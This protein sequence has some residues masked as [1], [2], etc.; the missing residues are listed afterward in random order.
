[1]TFGGGTFGGPGA[2]GGV[3]SD[4]TWELPDPQELL[5]RL[6]REPGSALA[7]LTTTA[8][9][10][11]PGGGG[12]VGARIYYPRIPAGVSMPRK[13]V[14]F[15]FDG[16]TPMPGTVRATRWRVEF[17]L[18]GEND[19]EAMKV[20][21]ALRARSWALRNTLRAT[22]GGTA[23]LLGFRQDGAARP[24][25]EDPD[26]GWRFVLT[27]YGATIADEAIG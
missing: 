26:T 3:G 17:R 4:P 8:G 22:A 27:T 13:A 20:E 25:L 6:L 24:G 15:R 23:G 7:E 19:D 21:R 2:A 12:P 5:R 10:N 9:E 1:M 18:Y 14:A 16:G 11:K